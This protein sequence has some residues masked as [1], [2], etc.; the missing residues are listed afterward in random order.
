MKTLLRLRYL[1]F[2]LTTAAMFMLAAP[3]VWADDDSDSDSD[4]DEAI[5]FEEAEVFFELN[6][7]DGDLGIHSAVD[8]GPWKQLEMEGPNGRDLLKIRARSRLRRQGLTQLF[9]ESAEP[10]FDEQSAETFFARFPEGEYEI[11][12][13]G[14]DGE[15]L[16][17]TTEVTHLMPAPPFATINTEMELADVC[18][19]D[20]PDYDAPVVSPP[21]TITWPAVTMSHPDLG[22][23]PPEEILVHN[24]EVVVEADINIGTEEEP[25]ELLVKTSTILPPGVTSYVVPDAF[26][27]LT[28]VWKYEVL[29][30]EDSF[31]QTAVES[32]FVN[33]AFVAPAP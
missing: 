31:N 27:A 20:D 9:Y 6:N 21:I 15:E 16:E 3:A 26:I 33:T 18:D 13:I 4:S 12:G 10:T 7:T 14:L 22:R 30:R 1:T 24:Y 8:G 19:E 32:C 25:E 17:S 2:V 23:D 28:D 29:V 5:P 11:E